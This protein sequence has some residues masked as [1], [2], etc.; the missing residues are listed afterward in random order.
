MENEIKKK[1]VESVLLEKI[2]EQVVAT[3]A[4]VET[5]LTQA[6]NTL[7]QLKAQRSALSGQKSILTDLIKA[8][9][10]L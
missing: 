4:Q 5:G 7:E 6:S 10:E 3:I 8:A 9:K 2:L 1:Y